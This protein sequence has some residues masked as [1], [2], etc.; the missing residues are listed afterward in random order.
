M[1][2]R[3]NLELCKPYVREP[4]WL[5]FIQP[6]EKP[7][8]V[9]A[10]GTPGRRPKSQHSSTIFSPSSTSIP[11]LTRNTARASLTPSGIGE[12]QAITRVHNP[13]S[14][15]ELNQCL[16]NSG[17]FSG[18]LNGFTR[19]FQTKDLPWGPKPLATFLLTQPSVLT[20]E[21]RMRRKEGT[22]QLKQGTMAH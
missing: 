5:G 14:L 21:T 4:C 11:F 17:R 22:A 18:D 1:A 3:E 7:S 12:P 16:S 13:F 8:L 20:I 10:L 9:E 6:T 19:E 15:P 2:L